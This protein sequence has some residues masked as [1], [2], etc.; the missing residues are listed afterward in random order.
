M[1]WQPE[2][3]VLISVV[4]DSGNEVV[5]KE[6]DTHVGILKLLPLMPHNRP[7]LLLAT[8]VVRQDTLPLSAQTM[9]VPVAVTP[10]WHL[11]T[12]PTHCSTCSWTYSQWDKHCQYQ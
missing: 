8:N 2:L 10:Y 7:H 12:A 4:V 3:T 1:P 9:A 11:R 6:E 5:A